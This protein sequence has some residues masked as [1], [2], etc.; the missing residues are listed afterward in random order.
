MDS[1]AYHALCAVAE[2]LGLPNHYHDDLYRWDRMGCNEWGSDQ[3]FVWYIYEMGTHIFRPDDVDGVGHSS[4]W[5]VHKVFEV[6]RSF[7]GGR[8]YHWDGSRLVH[9]RAGTPRAVEILR[10]ERKI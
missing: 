9:L 6:N 1:P 4:A 8:W 10:Q 5:I 3:Q 7:A 2:E